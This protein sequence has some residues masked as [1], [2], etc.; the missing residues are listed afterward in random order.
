MIRSGKG[1][2]KLTLSYHVSCQDTKLIFTLFPQLSSCS[3]AQVL[4]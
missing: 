1:V 2:E 4:A 3:L